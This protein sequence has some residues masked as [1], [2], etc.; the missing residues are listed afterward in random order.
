M[1]SPFGRLV[2]QNL[3]W[4]DAQGF[5]DPQKVLLGDLSGK[6]CAISTEEERGLRYIE[7]IDNLKTKQAFHW[8]PF[9]LCLE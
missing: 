2:L 5:A 6:L 1:P 3:T 8:Q 7:V 9:W 4:S